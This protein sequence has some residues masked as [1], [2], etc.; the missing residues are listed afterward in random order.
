MKRMYS[1]WDVFR[2]WGHN[3]VTSSKRRVEQTSVREGL[4]GREIG[5]EVPLAPHIGLDVGEQARLAI[6]STLTQRLVVHVV[7]G[8]TALLLQGGRRRRNEQS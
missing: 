1:E 2:E 8:N 3:A 4:R 6:A 5:L 7:K